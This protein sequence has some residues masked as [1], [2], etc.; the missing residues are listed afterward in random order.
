MRL[1]AAGLLVLAGTLAP[2]GAAQT[3]PP[4]TVGLTSATYPSTVSLVDAS[5]AGVL[6]TSG[7]QTE[8]RREHWL[9]KAGGAAIRIS[10]PAAQLNGSFLFART[11]IETIQ[12]ATLDGPP[13]TCK[14]VYDAGPI[15]A[16]PTGWTSL[17]WIGGSV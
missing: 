4:G 9:K 12:Y 2:T 8:S 13:R 17:D 11:V 5:T 10:W 15:A 6:Y 3:D 7:G 14:G 16:T 1:V